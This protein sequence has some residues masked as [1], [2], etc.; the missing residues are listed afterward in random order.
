MVLA[1]HTIRALAEGTIKVLDDGIREITVT[2]LYFYIDDR[3]QFDG[4]YNLRY[5]S[6]KKS[7]YNSNKIDD[8]YINLNNINFN[9]FREKFSKGRDFLVLSSLKKVDHTYNLKFYAI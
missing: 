4:D 7:D 8:T 1:N 6:R 3:F 9:N 2:N 5:W